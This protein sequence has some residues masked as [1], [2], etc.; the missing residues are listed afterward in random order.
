M[1][2]LIKTNSPKYLGILELRNRV[3]RKPLGLDI[4]NDDL[5]DE[6]ECQYLAF[7]TNEEEI[8]GCLKIKQVDT[9]VFQIMQM[10]VLP[11]YQGQGIGSKLLKEAESI[12]TKQGGKE[13][14]I[15]A[16]SYAIPFYSNNGYTITG[17]VFEKI[18]IPHQKMTKSL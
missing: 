12:V 3:L 1:I 18:N 4:R 14:V 13:V 8:I 6:S 17:D 5:S 15:E 9:D 11:D 16:R 10:A 7:F 2:R